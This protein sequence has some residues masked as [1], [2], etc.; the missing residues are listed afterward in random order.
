MFT[1]A[2]VIAGAVFYLSVGFSK[3]KATFQLTDFKLVKNYL[4]QSCVH[5]SLANVKSDVGFPILTV[6]ATLKKPFGCRCSD[7]SDRSVPSWPAM[8]KITDSKK[9]RM[10]ETMVDVSNDI[11][12]AKD[13]QIYFREPEK[14]TPPFSVVFECK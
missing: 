4:K 9:K 1:K 11:D 12:V 3:N 7:I 13:T 6:E 14:F 5:F 2:L 10:T 8:I